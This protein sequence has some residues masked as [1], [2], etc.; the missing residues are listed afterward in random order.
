MGANARIGSIL[1][2][3]VHIEA[4]SDV[5]YRAGADARVWFTALNEGPSSD[6]LRSVT[7]PYARAGQIRWDSNCDGSATVV[8]ALVLRPVKPNLAESPP[9]VPPFDA[10]HARLV[11]LNRAVPAGTTVPVTFTFDHAGSVT[12]DALVQPSNA[13]RPEPSNRCHGGASAAPSPS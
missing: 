7:S 13:V 6:V 2:R 10:Y 11:E 3:S 8:P 4:P 9:G 1:L 12:V 5:R